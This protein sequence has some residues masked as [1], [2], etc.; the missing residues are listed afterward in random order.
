MF[1]PRYFFL[2]EKKER[3]SSVKR[4]RRREWEIDLSPAPK[5]FS[6]NLPVNRTPILL[7]FFLGGVLFENLN[8]PVNFRG[9]LPLSHT[10]CSSSGHALRH[11]LPSISFLLPFSHKFFSVFLCLRGMWGRE[12]TPPSASIGSCVT[13]RT[14]GQTGCP[15]KSNKKGFF[16]QIRMSTN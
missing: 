15:T 12:E 3:D 1:L 8:F 2:G 5:I 7:H 6:R 4:K 14:A 10:P 9:K 13:F 11:F 16:C